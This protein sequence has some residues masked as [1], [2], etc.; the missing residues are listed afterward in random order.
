[1]KH[2]RVKY[3]KSPTCT[4]LVLSESEFD[5]E[6][7]ILG[8]VWSDDFEKCTEEDLI[9]LPTASQVAMSLTKQKL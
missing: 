8:F 5:V 4:Y 2:K 9:N 3:K 7:E 1:M 6:L